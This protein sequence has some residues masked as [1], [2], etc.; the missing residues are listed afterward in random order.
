M[1]VCL[2]MCFNSFTH[3]AL[4][5]LAPKLGIMWRPATAL[6]N[7]I[8]LH[9]A[10]HG[11]RSLHLHLLTLAPGGPHTTQ[12]PGH[13]SVYVSVLRPMLQNDGSSF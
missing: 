9:V 3:K 12:D 5:A 6:A 10:R 1:N 7:G 2:K 8:G 11:V 4:T 13:F